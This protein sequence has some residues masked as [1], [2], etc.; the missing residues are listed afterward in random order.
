MLVC[1]ISVGCEAGQPQGPLYT[2]SAAPFFS[3]TER[4]KNGCI[5]HTPILLFKDGNSVEQW[6]RLGFEAKR[7]GEQR[8]ISKNRFLEMHSLNISELV[9]KLCEMELINYYYN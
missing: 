8:Q 9:Q 4:D 7:G 5:K 2:M 1:V 3:E 6:G